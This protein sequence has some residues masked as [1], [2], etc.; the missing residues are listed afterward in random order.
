MGQQPIVIGLTGTVGSGKST[1]AHILERDYHAFLLLADEIGRELMEPGQICYHEIL[2]VFGREVL[3]PD[4]RLDREKL[5]GLVFADEAARER[6]DAC[7]HPHVT[8]VIKEAISMLKQD[9]M[10]SYLVVES[11]ILY[12]VHY[13][14]FCDQVWVVEASPETRDKRLM[15]SR[16]YSREKIQQIVKSQEKTKA[17]DIGGEDLGRKIVIRNDGTVKELEDFIKKVISCR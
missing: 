13:E 1:V 4:G 16:G 3:R 8:G 9:G 15:E 12:E 17:L 6:L 14:T 5:S 7:V 10:Y 11:A 2:Q